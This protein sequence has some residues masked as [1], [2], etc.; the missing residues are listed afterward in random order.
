M[1][2]PA[3]IVKFMSRDVR[4]KL[5]RAR[6]VLKDITSQDFLRRIESLSMK[7][8]LNATRNSLKIVLKSRKTKAS[9]SCG[10]VVVRSS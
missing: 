10:P 8:L 2:P 7:V 5:Y 4:E 1:F 3:I 9:N 6:K